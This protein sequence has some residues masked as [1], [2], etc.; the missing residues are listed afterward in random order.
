[1]D[2][3]KII[4][5]LEAAPTHIRFARLAAICD[6]FFGAP[7]QSKTS[8]RVY[9]TPWL[10]DPRINIQKDGDKAK[11]YQVKQVIKA[12]KKL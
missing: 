6:H 12:L 8:H 1:M 5:E 7:R 2:K 11:P 9:Q 10:G 4:A 3:A